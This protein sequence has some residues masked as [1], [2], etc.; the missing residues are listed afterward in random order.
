MLH[1]ERWKIW[2]I[3][4]TCLAGLLFTLPNFFPKETVAKWPG[5]LQHR[6]NLGLDLRGGSY[7][8]LEAD[9]A[10]LK[11]KWLKTV[12]QDARQKLRDEKIGYTG[13]GVTADGVRVRL[14]KPEDGERALKALNAIT[15]SV[16]TG[17]L[18]GATANLVITKDDA[19]AILIKPTEPAINERVSQGMATAIETI[20]K[21]I[22]SLGTLEPNIQRQG[23]GRIVVQ[24]PG[25]ENP[26]Q[27]KDLIGKTAALAFYEVDLSM[28]AE[29][30]EANGVPPGSK[31]FAYEDDEA[32]RYGKAKELLKEDPVVAGDDLV[33][34]QA[35]FDQQD[36]QP[37]VSFRFD[38][39]G[40]VKFG[41][42]TSENVGR[43]FAIVLDDKVISAPVIRSAITGGSG[44]ISGNFTIETANALAIQ[45]RS[46]ALPT[47]LTVVDE[48]SVGPGLGA[49]SVRAGTIA[50]V[51]GGVAVA[52]FI[53]IAYGLFGFF[54]VIAV[55]INLVLLLGIMSLLGQTLTLPGI[56]G[57]VLTIGMAVDSNV[58]I[59]ERIREELRAGKT[60]ISA[61]EAGFQ[62]A[63]V[64]I[65]DSQ[66]TTLVAGLIMFWLGTGPIR[67]F[68]VTL[69]IGLAT[70]VFTAV[71]ITRLII[72]LWLKRQRQGKHVIEVPV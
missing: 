52:V 72:T 69:T 45:L 46:G 57:I 31:V 55:M 25:A 66:L 43:P 40:S 23:L 48:R 37:I 49:D 20:R 54:S 30:A 63:L 1:F 15:Q 5:F 50:A 41:K 28:S 26:E 11:E 29:E 59:Y 32:K 65:I 62:R 9:V 16:S 67:G 17:I 2:G 58:L 51:V 8:L 36:N 64:T 27:I 24:V 56:A 12:V 39:A 10:K 7:L 3:V 21:R 42:Y 18:A 61:I 14:L 53:M 38:T 33:D 34:A 13:L 68:A 4:A 70:S 19:G 35:G 44:Q 22:D 71:T 60:A 47:D 6:I